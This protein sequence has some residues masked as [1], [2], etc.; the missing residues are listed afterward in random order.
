[1]KINKQEKLYKILG[2]VC[3]E[4]K[5]GNP[6]LDYLFYVKSEHIKNIIDKLIYENDL[7]V[8]SY[9]NFNEF[10]QFELSSDHLLNLIKKVNTALD[11]NMFTADDIDEI[12]EKISNK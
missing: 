4:G 10:G 11:L 3:I 12:F 5:T 6:V 8:P 1:M 2:S 7:P 9:I